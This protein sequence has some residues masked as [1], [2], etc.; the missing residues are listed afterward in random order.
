MDRA[1]ADQSPSRN[2][3]PGGAEEGE[4]GDAPRE[5]IALPRVTLKLM[6]VIKDSVTEVR[7][8]AHESFIA[9]NP[10]AHARAQ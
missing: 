2:A 8:R 9:R 10:Q 4:K 6:A 3:D 1:L 7:A 5:Q